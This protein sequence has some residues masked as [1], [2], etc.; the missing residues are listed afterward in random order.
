MLAEDSSDSEE[1]HVQMLE[2][3]PN[4]H[5]HIEC[6][7]DERNPTER[8]VESSPSERSPVECHHSEDS[9]AFHHPTVSPLVHLYAFFLLKFQTIFRL[10]DAALNVHVLL[11]FFALFLTAINCAYPA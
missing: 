3:C 9:S 2:S 6:H 4:K 10:S 7:H 5:D 11:S 1:L 8:P